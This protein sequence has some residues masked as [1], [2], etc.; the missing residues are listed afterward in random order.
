ML[1]SPAPLLLQIFSDGEKLG[2]VMATENTF[3]YA[4]AAMGA[5]AA[6]VV[7]D[8]GG[9]GVRDSTLTLAGLVALFFS[10]LV[11]V[12][13]FWTGSCLGRS[14]KTGAR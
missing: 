6:G 2:R 14:S 12:S 3:F 4:S 8:Y 5:L 7:Q 11:V 10:V 13:P 9:L 1:H